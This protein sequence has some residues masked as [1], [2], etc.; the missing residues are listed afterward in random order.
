MPPEG[1]AVLGPLTRSAIFLV[2]TINS[3]A[4]GVVRELLADV[5]GLQRSVGFRSLDGGLSCVVGIG[6]SAWDRLYGQPKPAEL[7][8]L[9]V[10]AGG[11]HRSVTTPGD[12]LFHI[13]AER[14]DLCFELETQIMARLYGSVAVAD[15]VHGFR[16]F[17]ARDVLGFVDG[18]ENPTASGARDAV[19]VDDDPGFDGGSYVI[20]QKYL[21]DMPAWNALAVED[22]E[23]VIGRRKLS[24]VELSDDEKPDNSHVALNT[25]TDPDGTEREILRDNMPFGRPASAEFGTYFIGYAKTPSVTERMLENMFVGSPPGNYDRILDFSTAVTGV[26]FYVPTADFLDNQPSASEDPAGSSLGIGSLK[27]SPRE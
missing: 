16:Y 25:I 3:G 1:Q 24:D 5:P 19:V 2:V 8:E 27:R 13:R 17:D 21:H 12:L 20:V 26:L 6:A 15:E 14:M 23:R 7:R 18:T 9:P 11:R 4:E 22:Q 10:F